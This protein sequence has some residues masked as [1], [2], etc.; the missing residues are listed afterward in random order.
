MAPDL[1]QLIEMPPG[2]AAA[3]LLVPNAVGRPEEQR[4]VWRCPMPDLRA[5]DLCDI[6]QNASVQP[7]QVRAEITTRWPGKRFNEVRDTPFPPM[8]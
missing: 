4:A 7:F 3:L 2:K 6:C 8:L 1:T 5:H